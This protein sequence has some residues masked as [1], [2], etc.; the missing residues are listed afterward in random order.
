M[1]NLKYSILLVVLLFPL[2]AAWGQSAVCGVVANESDSTIVRYWRE[3]VCLAYVHN[4]SNDKWFV[5]VDTMLSQVRRIAIPPEATVNDFRIFHDT[6]FVCGHYDYGGSQYGLLACFAVNDFYSGS[7]IYHS[8]LT[9]GTPMVDCYNGGPGT[10]YPME[11]CSDTIY[12]IVRLAVYDSGG[13][14]KIAFIAKNRVDCTTNL[15]VGVGCARFDGATWHSMFMYNK[16]A[17]EAYTDIIATQNYVVAVARTNDSARLALRIFPKSNFIY[18]LGGYPGDFMYPNKFGQGLA[19]LNVEG[20]VM[21][22][23]MEGDEFALA[24]HYTN[25]P[26]DGLA[27]RTF[28]ITGGLATLLQG[29]NAQVVRQLES[30]WKMR[31]VCYSSRL[32]RV[33]VLNDFDGGT[34]GSQASIVYQFQ[35]PTLATGFY[36][37][38][39]LVGYDLHALDTYG[40]TT[41]AFVASGNVMGRGFLTQYIEEL[42][43][44]VSCGQQD[45]IYAIIKEPSLYRTFMQTNLIEPLIPYSITP[46]VVETN[47][48]IP[49]C[50]Q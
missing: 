22:T 23:A 20:N 34:V 27:L 30:R 36:Y 46:F 6:V 11:P 21:A 24:Y 40:P 18:S 3:N 48:R 9:M 37:G 39:F 19:D 47:E 25:S 32:R 14:S 2:Y 42:N 29:V 35:L 16:Y 17:I 10:P 26:K 8:G 44:M 15:R 43:S 38:R 5:L 28:S 33:L 13:Y 49:I 50:N 31:D 45:M 4:N 7:G 41:E 12:D 1:K